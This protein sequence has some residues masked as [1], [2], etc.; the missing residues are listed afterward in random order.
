MF[1]LLGLILGIFILWALC[2][3]LLTLIMPM[4]DFLGVIFG[5]G[6]YK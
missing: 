3:G 4:L 6:K 5:K 1:S 2:D